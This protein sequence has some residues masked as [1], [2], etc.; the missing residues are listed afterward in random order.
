MSQK[1]I[2]SLFSYAIRMGADNLTI[3]S[4]PPE[5]RF[6][7][8]SLEGRSWSLN[9]P[10]KVAP[11]FLETLS[12]LLSW[13]RDE[14]PV[15]KYGRLNFGKEKIN[16]YLT[17]RTT[18]K[19][20]QIIIDIVKD[21]LQIW[22]LQQLGLTYQQLKE[23]R[24]IL[25]SKSGLI[26]VTSPDRQGKSATLSALLLEINDPQKNIYWMSQNGTGPGYE[27]PGTN[28]CRLTKASWQ[29]IMRHDSDIIII[30][31]LN[32]NDDLLM[33]IRAA[34]SGRLVVVSLT[35]DNPAT[36]K[37]IITEADHEQKL[38]SSKLKLIL[39]QTLSPWI[40]KSPSKIKANNRSLIGRFSLLK[41]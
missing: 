27:I 7:Y 12:Q 18:T 3:S 32:S 17:V 34:T 2:S 31:D 26:A 16:F 38:K 30:D 23:I 20:E 4:L 5:I 21:P 6:D 10:L 41:F 14:R 15:K 9:M 37:K 29:S 13:N 36:A 35:A 24:S 11:E 25:R 40:K 39:W 22:R 28:Y 1:I 19:G 8:Q 33:A